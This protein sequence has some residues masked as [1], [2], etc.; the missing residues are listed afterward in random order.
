MNGEQYELDQAW[1]PFLGA[2]S[3][4]PNVIATI[5]SSHHQSQNLLS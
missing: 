4:L 5:K 2:P 1:N 3:F